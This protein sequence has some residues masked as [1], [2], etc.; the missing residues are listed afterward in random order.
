MK[1]KDSGEMVEKEEKNEEEYFDEEQ[2]SPW[3]ERKESKKGIKLGKV[4]VLFVLLVP[5]DILFCHPPGCRG[6]FCQFMKSA[7]LFLLRDMQK[8]FKDEVTAV[9]QLPLERNDIV[10]SLLDFNALKRSVHSIV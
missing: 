9:S 10:I 7:F 2:Y 6:V 1:W 5:F 4:Q 8:K 3:A